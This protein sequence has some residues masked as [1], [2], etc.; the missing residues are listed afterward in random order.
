MLATA[1][2]REVKGDLNNHNSLT[3]DST[4]TAFP[5]AW[6]ALKIDEGWGDCSEILRPLSVERV[7]AVTVSSC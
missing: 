1:P 3:A 2:A 4:H 7:Y 5:L 6:L